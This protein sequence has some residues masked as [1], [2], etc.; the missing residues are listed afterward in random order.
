MPKSVQPKKAIELWSVEHHAAVLEEVKQLFAKK[1]ATYN[2]GVDL[3][4]Y[5]PF[6]LKSYAH[7]LHIKS[8][9]IVSIAKTEEVPNFESV[10][11]TAMDIINYAAFLIMWSDTNEQI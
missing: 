10:R 6:G 9:R 7:M 8:Q 4:N 1:N 5:F 3:E 2:G 11:D